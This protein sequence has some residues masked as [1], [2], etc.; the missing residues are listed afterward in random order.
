MR[1][2]TP[3]SS[4]Q[5]P[6]SSLRHDGFTLVELLIAATMM[7]VLMV[8]LSAHLHGG[9]TVW[10][11][12]TDGGESMQR[13]R[14]GW[15]R[16]ERDAANA[17]RYAESAQ[18]GQEVGMP[19]PPRFE[20]S[21]AAW[22]AVMGR[23]AEGLPTVRYVQYLCDDRDG[24]QGLWRLT[25]TV[26]QARTHQTPAAELLMLGCEALTFRYASE[27][28]PEQP[29]PLL[30]SPLWEEPELYLPRLIEASMQLADGRQ[31]IRLLAMPI[32]TLP[33]PEQPP[34]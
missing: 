3:A 4:F 9:L 14:V 25:Q 18:Y 20:R 5:P 15:E 31:V 34:A 28:P 22:Y 19:P 27:G 24:V 23:T 29:E 30:W 11:R 1:P 8:G 2:G 21:S 13:L 32:G 16:L 7:S 26:N 17:V 33:R 10:R 12:A 6:A